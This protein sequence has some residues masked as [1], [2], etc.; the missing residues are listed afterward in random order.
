MHHLPLTLLT[1]TCSLWILPSWAI[2]LQQTQR[3]H[4]RTFEKVEDARSAFGHVSRDNDVLFYLGGSWVKDPLTLKN[5]QNETQFSSVVKDM[6]GIHFGMSFYI[7]QW[8]SAGLDSSYN[9]FKSND[10]RSFSGLTDPVLRA[11][12]RFLSRRTIALAVMPYVGL[13]FFSVGSQFMIQGTGFSNIDGLSP[14][15]GMLINPLSD[16]KTSFGAKL[17]SEHVLSWSQLAINIGYRHSPG[18][19]LED[20]VGDQM[21]DY[22]HL[23]NTSVGLYI[24]IKKSWGAHLEYQRD[25]SFPLLNQNLNPNELYLGTSVALQKTITGFA[26]I[27]FGNQF[28]S[29]DGNDFRVS[30]GLKF[31]PTFRKNYQQRVTY[32]DVPD[33]AGADL[34]K[35][36]PPVHISSEV[37]PLVQSLQEPVQDT[38]TCSDTI[39]G[40]R[41]SFIVRFEHDIDQMNQ[42]VENAFLEYMV[43]RMR[44][45]QS[46][47]DSIVLTGHASHVG[48]E[49]YNQDLSR[50]RINAVESYLLYKR[51]DNLN[52]QKTQYGEKVHLD[53][54]VDALAQSRN[55]RVEVLVNPKQGAQFCSPFHPEG[56]K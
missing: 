35:Q 28:L 37:E 36:D 34:P 15:Q 46:D 23:L 43:E 4:S 25:W 56:V 13:P 20:V 42:S 48:S 30:A 45:Y 32:L 3:S 5:P 26:G 24:P 50:R 27:G 41:D 33:V 6:Y 29:N 53:Q 17:I 8:L 22:R 31:T 2:N 12:V 7:N 39:F 14:G 47:I 54:G 16:E 51:L 18:A 19:Y 1:F 52:I 10:N 21:I 11:K 55:R 44:R 40:D 9:L 38:D 49:A